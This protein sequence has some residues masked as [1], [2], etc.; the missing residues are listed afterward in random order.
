MS[1]TSPTPYLE[2]Q[3][4]LVLVPYQVGKTRLIQSPV[5]L[6]AS[7][8]LAVSSLSAT[9]YEPIWRGFLPR[10][11]TPS[12]FPRFL[13]PATSPSALPQVFLHWLL[14]LPPNC[15][16]LSSAPSCF[17][18]PV[19]A[20]PR[21]LRDKHNLYSMDGHK[22]LLRLDFGPVLDTTSAHNI[23]PSSFDS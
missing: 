22:H 9:P 17:R 16:A 21:I 1:K 7:S 5:S 19:Y 6:S 13:T 11:A 23:I 18:E 2:V 3:A 14:P 10:P 8:L 12:A 20:H 15:C 4:L